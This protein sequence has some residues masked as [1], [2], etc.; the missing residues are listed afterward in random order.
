MQTLFVLNHYASAR[1]KDVFV[2]ADRFIPERWHRGAAAAAVAAAPTPIAP[3]ADV[4][5]AVSEADSAESDI[6]QHH[7]F[8]CL[9]FGHGH[10]S[11]VGE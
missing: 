8:G 5:G 9:P 6:R 10:R 7:A 4:A 3:T 11:C 2:D 1:D